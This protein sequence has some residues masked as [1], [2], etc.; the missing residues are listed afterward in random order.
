M[1]AFSDWADDYYGE[2][3]LTDYHGEAESLRREIARLRSRL[4]NECE[5]GMRTLD[6]SENAE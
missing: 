3:D 2:H 6:R 5:D 4:R 1:S